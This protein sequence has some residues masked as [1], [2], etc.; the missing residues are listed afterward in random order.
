M[1][2]SSYEDGKQD[3]VKEAAFRRRQAALLEERRGCLEPHKLD[4]DRTSP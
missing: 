2:V 3:P 4:T 1:M